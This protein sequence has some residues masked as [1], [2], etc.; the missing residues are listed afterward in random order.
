MAKALPT[1]AVRVVHGASELGRAR[2]L[3]LSILFFRSPHRPTRASFLNV[4]NDV[5][6]RFVVEYYS[7]FSILYASADARERLFFLFFESTVSF[8]GNILP[9]LRR[10]FPPSFIRGSPSFMRK[11][12]RS[13][14]IWRRRQ[15]WPSASCHFPDAVRIAES[16]LV[17][18][19]P[20]GK[21]SDTGFRR[22]EGFSNA[23][24]LLFL[25][26]HHNR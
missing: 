20:N 7:A 1:G 17:Q 10:S 25:D 23:V 12:E 16:R 5:S 8:H 21:K 6:K 19:L 24:E 3:F 2:A 9:A 14:A 15:G 11:F 26:D 18:E 4:S 13:L 22:D